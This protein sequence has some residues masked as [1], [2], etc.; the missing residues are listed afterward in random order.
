MKKQDESIVTFSCL[1]VLL[2]KCLMH[3]QKVAYY[4]G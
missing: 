2:Y 1:K 3:Y 4:I